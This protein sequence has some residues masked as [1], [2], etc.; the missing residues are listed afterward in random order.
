MGQPTR[1]ASCK[2]ELAGDFAV[3]VQ[4]H[5]SPTDEEWERCVALESSLPL[6]RCRILVWTDGGAPNAKQRA[7]LRAAFKGMQPLTAVITPSAIARTVGIAI[8]WFNPRLRMFSPDQTE[9]ALDHH[10]T[11]GEERRLLKDTLARLRN[12]L[13]QANSRA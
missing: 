8:S 2:I 5:S 6:D 11:Q 13:T 10:G 9:A 12:D 1:A 7:R 4:S 3:V